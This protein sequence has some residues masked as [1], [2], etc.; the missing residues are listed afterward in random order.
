MNPTQRPT[1]W[2][3]AIVGLAFSAF[4]YFTDRNVA[5]VAAAVLAFLPA[6]ITAAGARWPT[7]GRF[8]PTEI[9]TGLAG[10]I[11]AL[12]MFSD[13]RD[14]S[15]LFSA[16]QAVAPAL[17]TG[18]VVASTPSPPAVPEP[19]EHVEIGDVDVESDL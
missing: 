14:V 3:A 17:V 2:I 1:E 16:I 7:L 8:R 12:I 13:N 15:A 19:P 11:A 5:A 4:A 18:F 10:A 6:L 9:A